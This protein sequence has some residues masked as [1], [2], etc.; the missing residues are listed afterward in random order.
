MTPRLVF[1]GFL[2]LTMFTEVINTPQVLGEA[3]SDR[4]QLTLKALT[5]LGAFNER[6]RPLLTGRIN[7][8]YAY[9]ARAPQFVSEPIHSCRHS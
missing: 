5:G 4:V 9:L 3:T 6:T 1:K 8:F 7:A 2:E